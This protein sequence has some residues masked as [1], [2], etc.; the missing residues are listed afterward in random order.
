MTEH[1]SVWHKILIGAAVADILA[2][3]LTAVAL[4]DIEPLLLAVVVILGLLV[5]GRRGRLAGAVLLGLI[6]AN[7]TFWMLTGTASNLAHREGALDAV[8]PAIHTLIALV[9][10]VGPFALVV[11]RI[12]PQAGARTL[13]WAGTG[14]VVLVLVGGGA[15]VAGGRRPRQVVEAGDIRLASQNT[16]FSKKTLTAPAGP[17]GVYMVNRDLFWH[18]FTIDALHVDLRVPVNAERRVEFTA[19][20]GTYEYYCRIPGHTLAGM[21]GTLTVR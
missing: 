12:S 5:L 2:N 21:K 3:L 20:P 4:S 10:L 11:A 19:P 17:I 7:I 8:I 6:F 16:A 9:G 18:T 14:V 15:A 13:R 1:T